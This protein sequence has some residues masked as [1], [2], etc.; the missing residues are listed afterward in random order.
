PLAIAAFGTPKAANLLLR[1]LLVETD[2]MIRFKV[3]RALGRLRADHPTLPLDEAVL[4]RAFQQTLSV[5]FDYMRWR[6]ALDEGARARPARRNEV[7]AALVA[8]LRDKQ[9]HSVERL[10]R[11]LNLITHDE[12]FAR[13]HHGLQSVRRETRAGSRELVEHLV[14]QRFR[15]PLL[16]LID[17][18]YEQSSLPAPQRLDRY[19]AALA[20]LAA[21]PVESVN[22]FATAQIAALGIHTLSDHIS[23]RPEFSLL[24]AEVVRRARR[25]L[26]GSK[27]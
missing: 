9:L 8:L 13:I 4:T 11:L 19:E 21:G 3:L 15:E 25:K 23:E 6:H 5:A 7:H 10:F 1:R 24:H 18:L 26:V 2:G 16:E 17:D 20:E 22:A 27:S 12:D 14:V